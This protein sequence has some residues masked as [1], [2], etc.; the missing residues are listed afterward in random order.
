MFNQARKFALLATFSTMAFAGVAN[1]DTRVSFSSGVSY[2][3]GDFGGDED[4]EVISIPMR[5]RL[6]TGNWSF[7]VSAPYLTVTG[8]ADIS[9]T[10]DGGGDGDGGTGSNGAT[11][12]E[13]TARG[14][15]DTTLAVEYAFRD[16]AGSDAYV[17]LGARARL[18]TGDEDKGLGGG[19]TDYTAT[20]EVGVS[21][22]RGGVHALVGRRF[23]GQRP[24]VDRQDGWQAELGGWLPAG[25]HTNIGASV[26]WREA[27]REG[28]EDPSEAGVYVSRRMSENL[29]ISITGNAGLSDASP[30]YSTG[31]RFT[32]RSDDMND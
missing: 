23:R 25:D 26:S 13:G 7:R 8:P 4:T 5:V 24:G 17:E 15:G 28:N 11:A 22:S 6:T 32:W 16:I 29:R 27:S 20:T 30:D 18:P 1:A 31:I 21:S 9:D 14:I 10:T 12:R 2:S 3:S 19:V